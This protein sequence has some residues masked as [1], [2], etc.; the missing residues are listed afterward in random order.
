MEQEH[1]LGTGG[2][3]KRID[4]TKGSFTANG[5][6]YQI[7]NT[8]SIERYTEMQ[9]LEKELAF[10]GSFRKL[11]DELRTLY[12]MLNKQDFVGCAVK[13]DTLLRSVAKV[14]E[15]EPVALKICCLFINFEGEDR[16]KWN[17][18]LVVKKLNDW[19]TEGLDAQDFFTVALNS[20]NGL[21][22]IYNQISQ[23]IFAGMGLQD[24]AIAPG[25]PEPTS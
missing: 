9:V 12:N 2:P 16:G 3:L 18:D 25:N 7:E 15:R 24:L 11:F 22:K 10:G 8:L 4:L 6:N 20:V 14:E 19:K 23:A 21:V 5:V 17:Q 13:V 1:V